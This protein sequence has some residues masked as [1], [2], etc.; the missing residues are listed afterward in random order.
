M[1]KAEYVHH[2][3]LYLD[4]LAGYPDALQGQPQG[5]RHS[6]DSVRE[7]EVIGAFCRDLNG[8][9]YRRALSPCR[10]LRQVPS[11]VM[12]AVR[13]WRVLDKPIQRQA[14]TVVRGDGW[15]GRERSEEK[16][17]GAQFGNADGTDCFGRRRVI[18][19]AGIAS[20]SSIGLSIMGSSCYHASSKARRRDRLSRARA[21]GMIVRPRDVRN[22]IGIINGRRRIWL[23]F[24]RREVSRVHVPTA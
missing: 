16:T 12:G 9:R 14:T 2:S 22:C 15:R 19:M 3:R 11:R 24:K 5:H 23:S 20:L 6:S 8:G 4:T 1:R 13:Q 21:S 17:R 18:T 10:L 7:H